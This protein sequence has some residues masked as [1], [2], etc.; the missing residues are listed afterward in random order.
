MTDDAITH[1][2]KSLVPVA[3]HVAYNDYPEDRRC[4]FSSLSTLRPN[5]IMPPLLD[6]I[7]MAADTLTEPHRLRATIGTVSACSM[8]L[9]EHYPA[10]VLGLIDL[11]LPG[12]DVNDVGKSCEIFVFL[13]DL[14]DTVWLVDFSGGKASS[15]RSS[16]ALTSGEATLVARSAMSEHVALQFTDR[17]MCII[18]NC[19]REQT[20][21]DSEALDDYLN[22]DEMVVDMTISETFQKLVSRCSGQIFDAVFRRIQRHVQTRILEPA[23]SG[24]ILAGMC[25]ACVVIQPEMTLKFFV[26]FLCSKVEA[27]LK[28]RVNLRKVDRELQYS[29]VLLSEV[30]DIKDPSYAAAKAES[31]D[32]PSKN[33]LTKYV[34]QICSRVLDR[35]LDLCE[36][37][38]N[39]R[40]AEVLEALLFNLSHIRMVK[41][42]L[43]A[44]KDA[45]N[46]VAWSKEEFSYCRLYS[47][48]EF[49]GVEWYVP[50]EAEVSAVKNILD[51]YL[52]PSL[53]ALDDTSGLDK[54]TTLRHLKRIK[55]IL[56]GAAELLPCLPDKK[57]PDFPATITLTH[58]E[59]NFIS[60]N[61]QNIRQIILQVR[62]FFY[63][64]RV[65]LIDVAFHSDLESVIITWSIFL[66]LLFSYRRF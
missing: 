52:R 7:R 4:V 66:C 48:E 15:R 57:S 65:F 17:C 51:R 27:I 10:E 23:V 42:F 54:E 21:Q 1:F 33:F 60:W 53:K 39:E 18:E 63:H 19:S 25:N 26:P 41:K 8:A 37:D 45:N 38:E 46:H 2:V 47:L 3:L 22:E 28:E 31:V 6:R 35:T 64:H 56:S 49:E 12:I 59:R 30:L 40:A 9:V 50:S 62:A 36:K 14:L 13:S 55:K 20:R 24:S 29:M 34:D 16:S 11:L 58:I 61:G 44:D 32:D 43:A 5:I